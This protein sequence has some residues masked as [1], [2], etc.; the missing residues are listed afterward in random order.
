MRP[1][2]QLKVFNQKLCEANSLSMQTY[3]RA[4]ETAQLE[5][6]GKQK[7]NKSRLSYLKTQQ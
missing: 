6:P 4:A 2:A 5:L 7:W 1:L 3:S